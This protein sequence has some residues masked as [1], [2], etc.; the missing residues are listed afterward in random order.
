[1]AAST[2][3][4]PEARAALEDALDL[5][6]NPSGQHRWAR[7][8]R[9]RLDDARDQ[10]AGSLGVAPASVTF[11]SGGTES[12]NLAVA[13][14]V[15]AVG[16]I[17]V[18]SAVE[19]HA[20]LEAVRRRGGRAVAVDS[21]GSLDLEALEAALV[22][23]GDVAVVS[24]MTANNETGRL[25]EIDAVAEV[26]RRAAP[27]ALVHTDAV[28][29][30]CWVDLAEATA[31]ADLVTLSAHKFGGPKGVGVLVVRGD[32]A[33][34]PLVVG[35]GQERGRRSGTQ[36]VAG[37]AATG[38][39]LAE[40]TRDRVASAARVSALADRLL[41]GLV[42]STV[43]V[44]PTLAG[45]PRGGRL[46]GICHV[47]VDGIETEALVVAA[48]QRDVM[49][50]AAASCASGAAEPSHVLASMGLPADR[51]A[52][53]VR[54]SLG[55]CSTDRDVERALVALPAAISQLRTGSAT[56]AG[57]DPFG[58]ATR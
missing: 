29:A 56:G 27:S 46:P 20:V 32:V 26:V 23:A 2:P 45:V 38:V 8:A 43:G 52:G 19:H 34:E 41:D 36:D 57:R 51:A 3:L 4:R 35:G 21:T 50:S 18:C 42:R 22:E 24:V 40:A 25:Q 14:V 16:G 10:V 54:L 31:G 6:G 1:H 9:R 44:H 53:S 48:E 33:I 47:C 28:Q 11:T 15:G 5:V 13:G 12:D 55:W 49:L 58:G 7:T 30:A 17:P 37:I 39:A